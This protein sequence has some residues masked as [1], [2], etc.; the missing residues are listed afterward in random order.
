MYPAV[1]STIDDECHAVTKC[2]AAFDDIQ[3]YQTMVN[4]LDINR[5]HLNMLT[6][7]VNYDLHHDWAEASV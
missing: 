7:D 2:L 1:V 6:D 3:T 4:H 5:N